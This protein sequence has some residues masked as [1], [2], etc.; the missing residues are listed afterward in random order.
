MKAL[1]AGILVAGSVA[2]TV[3]A[4]DTQTYRCEVTAKSAKNA[5]HM[6]DWFQISVDF[7]SG[8]AEITD[9]ISQKRKKK[10]HEGRIRRDTDALFSLTWRALVDI[11][12]YRPNTILEHRLTVNRAT[13]AM[14]FRS[15]N[16]RVKGN[17]AGTGQCRPISS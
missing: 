12:Y 5:E 17:I 8:D 11:G 7:Y 9:N 2:G 15:E 6:P 1:V 10:T 13:G 14:R 16:I 3:L 4:Q